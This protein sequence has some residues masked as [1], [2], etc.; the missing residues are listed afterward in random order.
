MDFKNT[1][2]IMTSNIG[3][4]NLTTAWASGEAGFEDA[5]GRVMDE[6]KKHFRPEFLNRVDDI[7]VFHPLGEEQLTHIVDL[8]LHDLEKLLRDRKITITLTDKARTL[9]FRSG[10]D[11]AYGARPLT[12]AIQRLLQDPLAMCIL[13]GEVR[14]GDHVSVDAT[15]DKL[16]FSATHPGPHAVAATSDTEIVTA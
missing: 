4:Q 3:A 11:R 1:V 15:G 2:L 8:R 5:K 16:S 14:N 10:Y 7:V 12:R 13:S 6:L 9:L